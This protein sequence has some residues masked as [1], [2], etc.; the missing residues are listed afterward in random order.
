MMA[1]T[2]SSLRKPS[3]MESLASAPG[4]ANFAASTSH[5]SALRY[6]GVFQLTVILP[7]ASIEPQLAPMA[8]AI[9]RNCQTVY[10]PWYQ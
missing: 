2:L 3:G 9:E 1:T 5:C 7:L 8:W 10:L 6:S 4:G